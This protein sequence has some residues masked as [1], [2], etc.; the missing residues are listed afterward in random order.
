MGH[1][2]VTKAPPAGAFLRPLPAPRTRQAG[3][4]RKRSVPVALLIGAALLVVG[5]TSIALGAQQN[6]GTLPV[7]ESVDVR[8]VVDGDS[9]ILRDGRH[10]RLIGINAPEFGKKNKPDQPLARAA[11]A[12][13]A[14]LVEGRRVRL[15]F[16]EERTDRYRRTLAHVFLQK[17]GGSIQETLLRQGLAWTVAIPPNVKRLAAHQAAEQEARH[18]KRGVWNHPAYVPTAA[19]RLTRRDTGFRLVEG[20]VLRIHRSGP[21]M[22]RLRSRGR[23]DPKG[24][25]FELAP[26]FSMW[27]PVKD[28]KYFSYRPEYLLGRR[29][30]VRG[31]LTHRKGKLRVRVRHPAMLTLLD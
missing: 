26:N 10:V 14:N 17:G 12:L 20:T 28:W 24:Y 18:K 16:G 11:R 21:R 8:Y 2:D 29:I 4:L 27:V 19:D 23:A 15:A 6:A 22:D 13:L 3:R 30:L 7:T 25:H 9:L 31:W 1:D 5:T